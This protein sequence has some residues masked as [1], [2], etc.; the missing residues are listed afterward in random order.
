MKS[1]IIIISVVTLLVTILAGATP[2]KLAL[3]MGAG[4]P[5]KPGPKL[6]RCNPII[7]NSNLNL[8]DLG[9]MHLP[10]ASI[11]STSPAFP[12]NQV[13]GGITDFSLHAL[14]PFPLLC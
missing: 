7:I 5:F 4:C 6:E 12:Q 13:V 9:L 3:K 14:T 11:S 1:K 10:L 8:D 2:L